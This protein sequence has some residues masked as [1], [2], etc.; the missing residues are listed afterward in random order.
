MSWIRAWRTALSLFTVIPAGAPDTLDER[1]A[2]RAVLLMPGVGLLL[3]L[4]GGC[5]VAGVGAVGFW[6]SGVGAA[7]DPGLRRL[8]GAVLAIA[9]LALLTGGL[10][11]DGLA[12]TADGLGSRRP[13]SAALD[14]MRR[15]DVGPMGVA[16]LVLVL[17]IQVAAL[18]AV[19]NSSAAGLALVLAT[20]TGRVSV[21]LA[22]GSP[23]ARPG[24][25]GALVAGRTTARGRLLSLILL[26]SAVVA[27]GFGFGEVSSG[28]WE[29]AVRGLAAAAV[30]LAA[31]SSVRIIAVRRL[32]GVTGDVFGAVTEIATAAVLVA[33]ALIS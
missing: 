16:A 21:V 20:V 19:P 30:G 1:E 27:A 33:C 18:A 31:G 22:T 32:G 8:L 26:G 10:H 28:G 24:G 23:P 13:A 4:L 17:L 9:L 7:G 15:S 6:T 25:F 11:L 5:V 3:G 2:A 29:L 12:D 14:I